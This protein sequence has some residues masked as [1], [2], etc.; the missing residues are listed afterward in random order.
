MLDLIHNLDQM[1]LTDLY[2]TLYPRA[3]EYTFFLSVQRTFSRVDHEIVLSKFKKTE[4]ISSTFMTIQ[5]KIRYQQQNERK[6][7][8]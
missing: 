8:N 6:P 4:N 3:A 1:D 7:E 5:Y 2:S